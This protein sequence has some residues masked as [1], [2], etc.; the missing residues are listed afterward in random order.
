MNA[1]LQSLLGLDPFAEDMLNSQLVKSSHP[2]SLYRYINVGIMAGRHAVCKCVASNL[3]HTVLYR[4]MWYVSRAPSCIV[5]YPRRACAAR[6]T[7]HSLCVC[8]C[9][10]VTLLTA[11]L[12]TYEYKVRYESKANAVL[13]Y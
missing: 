3:N 4:V 5:V 1:V 11:T 13:K 7:V 10:S 8:I 12:L 6:V 9:V 2:K